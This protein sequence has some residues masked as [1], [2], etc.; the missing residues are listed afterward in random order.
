MLVLAITAIVSISFP[1]IKKAVEI[2]S[3]TRKWNEK[4]ADRVE[5]PLAEKLP[6]LA[7]ASKVP[8]NIEQDLSFSLTET[9]WVINEKLIAV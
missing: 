8:E 5:A 1:H 7:H 3:E 9:P 4:W 6:S 2:R